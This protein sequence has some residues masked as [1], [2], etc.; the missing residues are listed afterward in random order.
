MT[1][2][3]G[4]RSWATIEAGHAKIIRATRTAI[5][6]RLEAVG[7]RQTGAIGLLDWALK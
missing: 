6:G 7:D 2:R 5:R 4:D 3:F 1:I